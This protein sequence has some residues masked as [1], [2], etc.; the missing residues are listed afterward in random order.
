MELL[1]WAS[2]DFMIVLTGDDAPT[3]ARNRIPHLFLHALPRIVVDTQGKLV[4]IV[5]PDESR[6]HISLVELLG[7]QSEIGKEIHRPSGT[8]LDSNGISEMISSDL[9]SAN[10]MR[11]SNS[12]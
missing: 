12:C 7:G 11:V 8:S 6:V 1:E 2:D 10:P 4:V 9:R 3:F 5:H